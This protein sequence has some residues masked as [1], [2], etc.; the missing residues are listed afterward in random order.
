LQGE[1]GLHEKE[2]VDGMGSSTSVMSSIVGC[3]WLVGG[4]EFSSEGERSSTEIL[5]GVATGDRTGDGE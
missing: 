2:D 5:L 4:G 1:E 3:R